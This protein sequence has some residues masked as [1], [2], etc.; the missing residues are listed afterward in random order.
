ML[1]SLLYLSGYHWCTAQEQRPWKSEFDRFDRYDSQHELPDSAILF[2][3]SSSIRMWSHVSQDFNDNHILNRGFGGSQIKDLIVYFDRVIARYNPKQIIVYSGD[4]DIAAGK[5]ARDVYGDLC[6][7]LGMV[8]V[9]FPKTPVYVIS[10]KP[11]LARWSLWPEMHKTNDLIRQYIASYSMAT[12]INIS[13]LMLNKGRPNP[14]LYLG[15]GLHMN[16][17]GYQLWVAQ[18]APFITR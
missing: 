2:T 1:I 8:R 6:V 15:D 17:K 9:K 3:G 18:L 10:I 16:E 4:N 11:S 12:F 7:L 13:S 14:A 5:S